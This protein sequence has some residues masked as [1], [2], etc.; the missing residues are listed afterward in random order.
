MQASERPQR[1]RLLWT[2]ILFFSLSPIAAIGLTWFYALHHH[3]GWGHWVTLILTVAMTELAITAG[4]HRL[5]THRSYEAHRGLKLAFLLLGAAAFEGSAMV[6]CS[7]HRRH[8]RFADKDGDPHNINKG[9]WWA[10]LGWMFVTEDPAPVHP[11]PHDL[12]NDPLIAWQERHY[13]PLAIFMAFVLPLLIGAMVGDALGGLIFGGVLRLVLSHHNTFFINSL[14]HTFGRRPYTESQTARDSLLMAVLAC[15]EGFHNFHH[16]FQ[17]DYRNGIRWYHWDPTKWLIDTCA[18][19][20]LA[21]GLKAVPETEILKARLHTDYDRLLRSGLASDRVQ[22]LKHKVEDAQRRWRALGEDYRRLKRNMQLHS[23]E[24]VL[25]LRAELKM[26]RLEFKMAR[27]Q[28]GVYLRT[29]RG[30]RAMSA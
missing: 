29:W 16:K 15:G 20:G 3:I 10:H 9:F 12:K 22:A 13:V 4:Y 11:I 8:H 25:H 21:H 23:Q 27:A 5:M 28:W 18:L 2:N 1:R 17:A 26:A 30:V 19:V 14:A 24:R 7:D 6:W